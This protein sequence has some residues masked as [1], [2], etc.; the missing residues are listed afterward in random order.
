MDYSAGDLIKKYIQLRK[1][2][3]Q[4]EAEQKI[5]I[6]K[7]TEA[8]EIIENALSEIMHEQKIDSLPS[9]FGTAYKSNIMTLKVLDEIAFRDF[10]MEHCPEM[11]SVKP[12]KGE[13]KAYQERHKEEYEHGLVPIPGV[14]IGHITNI[15]VR[16]K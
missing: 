15:N 13:V 4:V 3:Q 12:V 8:M 14:E 5:A 10:A 16:K 9:E 1:K 2:K 11:A 7:Y 6:A